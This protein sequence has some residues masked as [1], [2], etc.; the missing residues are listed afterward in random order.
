MVKK[1]SW[2][3][4]SSSQLKTVLFCVESTATEST[5]A[6]WTNITDKNVSINNQGEKVPGPS[7]NDT[8]DVSVV[9]SYL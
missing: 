1:D 6:K 3:H 7:A 9:S 2:L 5:G 8:H 4:N